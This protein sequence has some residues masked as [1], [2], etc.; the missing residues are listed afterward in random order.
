MKGPVQIFLL[1]L[2]YSLSQGQTQEWFNFTNGDQISAIVQHNDTL[3]IGTTCGLVKLNRQTGQT[4]NVY[5]SANS[6]LPHLNIRDIVIGFDGVKWIATEQ[7]LVKFDDQTWTVYTTDDGLPDMTVNALALD[8]DGLPIVGTAFNGLGFYQDITDNFTVVNMANTPELPSDEIQDLAFDS[9]SGQLLIA[10]MNGLILRSPPR[11][12]TWNDTSGLPANQISCVAFD[13]SLVT[14]AGTVNNGAVRHVDAN[15]WM[16]YQSGGVPPSAFPS[17]D[18]R[19]IALDGLNRP[20]IGTQSGGLTML[21][22]T[23]D[24]QTYNT[25][26]SN[27]PDNG[28]QALLI[29]ELDDKWV[30]TSDGLAKLSG[31]IWTTN[32]TTANSGLPGRLVQNL[33]SRNQNVGLW[34]NTGSA[35][36]LYNGASWEGYDNINSILPTVPLT[37]ILVNGSDLLFVGSEGA[38]GFTYDGVIWQNTT[39]QNSNIPGDEIV[40]GAVDA[41]DVI[42]IGTYSGLGKLTG[43]GWVT[44]NT[45]NSDLQDNYIPSMTADRLGN[46]YLY[47]EAFN[48][49][50]TFN[51]LSE[52]VSPT[53][54]GLAA[55]F[56][57]DMTVDN[58]NNLWVATDQGLWT[59]RNQVWALYSTVNS[60]LPSNIVRTIAVSQIGNIWIGTN[61]GLVVF[62]ASDTLV[63]TLTNSGLVDN[64][65]FDLTFDMNGDLWVGTVRG[66]ALFT[67]GESGSPQLLLSDEILDFGTTSIG[68]PVARTVRLTNIGNAELTISNQEISGTDAGAFSIIQNTGLPINPGFS[69]S[70]GIQF[71]PISGGLSEAL[72]IITSNAPTSP[73]TIILRGSANQ[74]DF[75]LSTNRVD[76]GLV[77]PNT[78]AT[79]PVQLRN[80]GAADL[81]IAESILIGPADFSLNQVFP[82]NLTIA[83]DSSYEFVVEFTPISGGIQNGALVFIHNAPTS[84]DT[85][86][87]TGSGGSPVMAISSTNLEFGRVLVN[88][89]KLDTVRLVNLG[90]QNLIFYGTNLTAPTGSYFSIARAAPSAPVPPGDTAMVIIAFSPIQTQVLPD[91]A[92]LTLESNTVTGLDSITMSGRGVAFQI[93]PGLL[94]TNLIAGSDFII[95]LPSSQDISDQVYLYYKDPGAADFDSLEFTFDVDSL[96]YQ[97]IIESANI[98]A[99]GITYY[100]ASI[101]VQNIK[102]ILSGGPDATANLL[103]VE[104]ESLQSP[105]VIL[106]QIYG[107]ISIPYRLQDS[108]MGRIFSDELREYN[109]K[110]WRIFY[111]WYDSVQDTA[112][113]REYNPA[114]ALWDANPGKAFWVITQDSTQFDIDG[115]QS[116]DFRKP[117][118]IFLHKGWNQ[119]GNPFTFPVAWSDIEISGATV[120]PPVARSETAYVFDQ[121]VLIPWEGYFV[122]AGN[123]AE[124]KVPP[125][126]APGFI[127]KSQPAVM[128]EKD[129]W[130]IR[131]KAV[132]LS[133]SLADNYNIIG[134]LNN[135]TDRKDE[136]DRFE[137]PAIGKSIEL[138]IIQDNLKY[139]VNYRHVSEGSSWELELSSTQGE[140]LSELIFEPETE[141]PHN[142]GLWLLDINRGA[143]VPLNDNRSRIETPAR[144]KLVVGTKKFAETQHGD[145]PL[146][147][148]IFE[149]KQ[150]YPNPFNPVTTIV[151]QLA[152]RSPVRLEIMNIRGKHVRTLINKTQSAGTHQIEWNGQ[153][154]TGQSCASGL[155]FYRLS[156]P[157]WNTAKKMIRLQ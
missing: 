135:A 131:L 77:D 129:E 157:S 29:D 113:Y 23:A 96:N 45:Q 63:Y 61:Q 33:A 48:R 18:I 128:F 100:I 93:D 49:I 9:Q 121:T 72:I 36:T 34:I 151:Y 99:G 142:F 148:T 43:T 10:S 51:T 147:P 59:L 84:P 42:W 105:K 26:N 35:V 6:G 124:L 79:Q 11:W 119:I 120:D 103:N 81:I 125:V 146:E 46:L 136:Q 111:W 16:W 37:E 78:G 156:T 19:C 85:L 152:E 56:V 97:V 112:Y 73:D 153:D 58:Q 75:D 139:A 101:D 145:I 28:V 87:L 25:A 12:Q 44:Y 71:T 115:A 137:P 62:S 64:D 15:Q 47:S 41:D 110:F 60:Q 53:P 38:G 31:T 5:H 134:M 89:T 39:S 92:V 114:E 8:T 40:S 83:P 82:S 20:W 80:I 1:L 24:W 123:S 127:P 104:T 154:D 86:F 69:D 116:V 88:T 118:Q 149:L 74:P 130:A 108:N 102:E 68:V 3:W 32:Y 27:I 76:F 141:L 54:A 126:S 91:M 109:T 94:P 106:S 70:I 133:S 150:N 7:G 13:S 21:P 122:F 2:G 4:L 67:A 138:N 107:M 95:T 22:M 14:W 155:Y 52:T 90:N 30:G 57:Q 55:T 98:P 144:L 132:G 17:N 66:L 143:F 140:E 50:F 117:Y 65:I